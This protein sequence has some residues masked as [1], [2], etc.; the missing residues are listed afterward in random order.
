MISKSKGTI[1][2]P[3][4]ELDTDK[5]DSPKKK[6]TNSN[7]FKGGF[8]YK[9][10]FNSEWCKA[11]SFHEPCKEDPQSSSVLFAVK[12]KAVHIKVN[13]WFFLSVARTI[14][15]VIPNGNEWKLKAGISSEDKLFLS[16]YSM[17]YYLFLFQPHLPLWRYF[18]LRKLLSHLAW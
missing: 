3:F 16:G 2:R 12:R 8:L 10:R 5:N 9:A 13:S 15:K 6:K 1:K 11:W 17:F 7:K 14:W 4:S 18:I